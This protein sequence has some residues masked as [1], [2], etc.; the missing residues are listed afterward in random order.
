MQEFSLPLI[1]INS[2]N[3][4]QNDTSQNMSD[5]V[6][7]PNQINLNST[8]SNPKNIIQH[9]GISCTPIFSKSTSPMTT[10][11]NSEFSTTFTKITRQIDLFDDSENENS[12]NYNSQN[13]IQTSFF[14][15]I[16]LEERKIDNKKI[17]E[18]K[19]DEQ[20][21]F[22]LFDGIKEDDEE[23]SII[24]LK[25]MKVNINCVSTKTNA[26]FSDKTN[27]FTQNNLSNNYHE[28]MNNFRYD[29]VNN[30]KKFLSKT[31]VKKY[32]FLFI[33]FSAQ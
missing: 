28:K 4:Q 25:N 2:L 31:K 21:D 11:C 12:P 1:D 33:N 13:N 5:F 22:I 9:W 3:Q 23:D 6:D 10:N 17:E 24:K 16:V 7:N 27:L 26:C 15:N 20:L 8:Q 19:I 30:S 18:S 32:N 29:N 14:S